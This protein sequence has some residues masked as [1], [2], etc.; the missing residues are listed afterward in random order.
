MGK[1][2]AVGRLSD[3]DYILNRN[4]YLWAS[5]HFD[6]LDSNQ[7]GSI[8]KP[9]QLRLGKLTRLAKAAQLWLG[10]SSSISPICTSGPFKAISNFLKGN[11]G[12]IQGPF[13]AI[14]ATFLKGNNGP[15]QRPSAISVISISGPIQDHWQSL[16]LAAVG[17]FKGISNFL[18]L[19][20]W[21]HSRVSAI[22]LI[23]I[24]GPIQGHWQLFSSATLGPFKEITTFS[25]L[26]EWADS[27]VS[28]ISLIGNS[29][30]NSS[31][32]QSSSWVNV[33]RFDVIGSILISS[34]GP[35][36]LYQHCF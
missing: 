18:D 1:V 14:T 7:L 10:S 31:Y 34:N 4:L 25:H 9:A 26:S 8:S 35:T 15:I 28:A 21:F 30:A 6:W 27:R 2:A 20:Q 36:H 23:C 13:R 17:P 29:G 3:L 19:Y 22:S 32:W 11:N 5:W 33:G 16:S 12:P 24:S